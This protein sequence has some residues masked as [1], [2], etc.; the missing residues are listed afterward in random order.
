MATYDTSGGAPGGSGTAE[1]AR[2]QAT[3][4][5]QRAASAGG[6]VA[7]TTME[8]G[9]EV[10]TEAG[11][12]ARDLAHEARSQVRE[13]ATTQRDRAAGGL[14]A[15][16]DELDQMAERGGQSGTATEIA[17]Q[18]A[19]RTREVAQ[20]LESREPGDLVEEIRSYARRRPGM[21]LLGAAVAGVLAGR[22]TKAVRTGQ[23]SVDSPDGG[24]A[25]RYPTGG[26]GT[27]QI[28]TGQAAA[29]VP[30]GY[31]PP[32]ASFR[33]PGGYPA[34][35]SGYA[36][37]AYPE[38]GYAQPAPP[39]NPTYAGRPEYGQQGSP[40]GVP[41]Q[42]GSADPGRVDPGYAE[43]GYADPGYAEPGYVEPGYVEP[44]TGVPGYG[45]GTGDPAYPAPGETAEYESEQERSAR[46]GTP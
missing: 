43:Q 3:A 27:D 20:F 5:G 35:G 2:E 39:V 28:G 17:R 19:G 46:G 29:A 4:V 42:S 11:R 12:Q 33:D 26:G 8:Q 1:V 7:Q 16:S 41:N 38:P 14:R 25:D 21:F 40:A 10:A 24:S 36:Q 23:S 37:P 13:Q 18:A 6:D 15:L 30:A 34:S 22:L 31:L 9:K 32:D 44:G 45:P